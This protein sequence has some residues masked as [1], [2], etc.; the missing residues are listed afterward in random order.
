MLRYGRLYGPGTWSDMS[1]PPPAL[2]VDAAAQ[3]A[4]LAVT[5]GAPGIYNIAD[6]DGAVSIDKA[7][8]RIGLSTSL[9]LQAMPLERLAEKARALEPVAPRTFDRLG[10]ADARADGDI[11]RAVARAQLEWRPV[12]RQPVVR[13]G[14]AERLAQPRPAPSRAAAHRP[15]RAAGAWRQARRSARIARISTAL[16]EPSGSQTKFTHQ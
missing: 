12:E 11:H 16:A 6:D 14:D 10:D 5:R 9:R 8:A 13:G 4:L 7:Q 15:G 1:A 2:H 3:A